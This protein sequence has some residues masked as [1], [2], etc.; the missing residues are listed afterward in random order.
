MKTSLEKLYAVYYLFAK[1]VHAY[2][3]SLTFE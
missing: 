3:K 1:K 2:L